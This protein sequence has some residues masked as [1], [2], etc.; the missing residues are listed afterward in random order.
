[1][2]SLFSQLKL[3]AKFSDLSNVVQDD[4]AK[5]HAICDAE[6]EDSYYNSLRVIFF[7]ILMLC[8]P[9]IFI[10]ATATVARSYRRNIL[11]SITNTKSHNTLVGVVLTGIFVTYYITVCDVAAVCYFYTG[12][13]ELKGTHNLNK[14]FNVISV[15]LLLVIDGVSCL[16]ILAMLSYVCAK[17]MATDPSCN[18]R[19]NSIENCMNKCGKKAFHGFLFVIS[20][21]QEE[22][23]ITVGNNDDNTTKEKAKK[24]LNNRLVRIITISLI[25]PLLTIS[26]HIGFILVAWLTDT[27]QASSIGLIMMAVLLYM[28]L[29]FR[30]CYTVNA[31]R[32]QE[33]K[34]CES[35][36]LCCFPLVSCLKNT[37]NLLFASCICEES[38]SCSFS[39]RER[40]DITELIETTNLD[41]E[42]NNRNDDD[43]FNSK[44][45]CIVYGWGWVLAGTVGITIGGFAVLPILAFNAL[46]NILDTFEVFVLIFSLLITYKI[47]TLGEPEIGRF[48]RKIRDKYLNI[49]NDTN[50]EN[51]VD[52]RKKY[53]D[54]EAAGCLVGEMADVVIHKLAQQNPPPQ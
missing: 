15:I 46:S 39:Q 35:L 29:M 23:N 8:V 50:N 3:Y 54:V 32:R 25:A 12:N 38:C 52:I 37:F 30:Q 42:P 18:C 33:Y 48:L 27:P 16:F 44:A 13:Q 2:L 49:I 36:F 34:K 9:F 19:A 28:L 40:E 47:L 26:S 53:D 41:E 10:T 17:N 51:E 11:K 21:R 7:F 45:F 4:L 20:G 6:L 31:K 24:K 1:M 22:W 43:M 14:T 5:A